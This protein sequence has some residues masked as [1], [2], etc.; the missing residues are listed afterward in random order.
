MSSEV[1]LVIELRTYYDIPIHCPFCGVPATSQSGGDWEVKGC[2]HLELLIA[3]EVTLHVGKQLQSLAVSKGYKVEQSE[4]E[5]AVSN[6]HDEDD[7]PDLVE[8]SEEIA[9]AVVFSQIVGP[10]SSETSYTVFAYSDAEY[11]EFS[12]LAY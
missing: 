3:A 12:K 8:L 4:G 10:P 7:F 2:S 1:S 6:P 5:V 11:E 9:D